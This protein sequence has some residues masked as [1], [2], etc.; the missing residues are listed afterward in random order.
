[1]S[2]RPDP[3]ASPKRRFTR[4]K[5]YIRRLE[6]RIHD[7]MHKNT[8]FPWRGNRLEG[9]T[10]HS[11]KFSRPIPPSWADAA[12]DAIEHLRSTLDQSGYAAALLGGIKEPKNSYFP[13]ADTSAQLA[14]VVKGRCKDLPEA[15]ADLFGSFNPYE[16][17]NYPLWAL[18]KLCNANKHRLL[19]PVAV[20]ATG[21]H[22]NYASFM[23]DPAELL[24]R[25]NADKHRLEFARVGP[26]GEF[27][28]DVSITTH[29]VFDEING[30][31][32]G[33]AVGVLNAIAGEVH[34]VL[35]ATE[36]ECRRLGLQ[37]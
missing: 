15:I 5:Q 7:F 28:Y 4:A 37:K 33:P 27:K 17:G 10:V 34:R 20:T 22:F 9:W 12:G 1:M 23:K 24:M 35:M 13:F 25:W 8:T 19:V 29:I 3:F 6:K 14:N 21:L 18:N 2:K 32:G 31:K 26:G 16:T 30:V 36:A 11:L